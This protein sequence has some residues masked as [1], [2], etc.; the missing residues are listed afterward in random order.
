MVC[1]A[2]ESTGTRHAGAQVSTPQAMALTAMDGHPPGNF[3]RIRT[4]GGSAGGWAPWQLVAG[5]RLLDSRSL[6]NPSAEGAG[7]APAAYAAGGPAPA[8]AADGGRGSQSG[9]PASSSMPCERAMESYRPATRRLRRRVS[10]RR[11]DLEGS[12][13]VQIARKKLKG[14]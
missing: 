9:S 1:H 13:Q 14:I 12:F 5:E 11:T 6:S 3:G 8:R 10:R 7:A 2:G 4:T